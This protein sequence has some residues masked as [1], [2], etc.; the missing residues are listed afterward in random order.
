MKSSLF[1][2]ATLLALIGVGCRPQPSSSEGKLPVLTTTTMITDMVKQVGGDDIHLMPLMGAGVDPHLYKPSASDARKMREAKVTF[3]NGLMLEGRMTDLFEQIKKD[4]G[5]V[6][7]LGAALPEAKRIQA[8]ETHPDPHIWFDPEVW[9]SCVDIV[10]DGLAKASPEHAASF[11]QRGA[12]L[13]AR[14]QQV[15]EKCK[16]LLETVPASERVLITSHDAFNYFGRAFNME[17]VGVQGI[18]TISEAGL[19][20]IAKTVDFI[21]ERKVKA[22]F[23]ESS[24]PHAI[25]ERIARD[26]GAKVGGELFSDALGTPGD[27]FE[28]EGTTYDKGTYD[29]ALLYSVTTIVHAW[30]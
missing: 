13:K 9:I 11:Q 10:V 28:F 21:K 18:S 17:V 4:G 30:Q 14:Y 1:I 29:G 16:S 3:Y 7:E 23:V 8:D 19:A 26:S 22:I 2:L 20:D 5:A 27:T 24:V 25:I 15:F 6:Y 12:E